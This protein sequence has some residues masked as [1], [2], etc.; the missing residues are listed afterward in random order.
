MSVP[1]RARRP[2]LQRA[3]R[4]QPQGGVQ[5]DALE[6]GTADPCAPAPCRQCTLIR[7]MTRLRLWHPRCLCCCCRGLAQAATGGCAARGG[8][9]RSLCAS[10]PARPRALPQGS[11]QAHAQAWPQVACACSLLPMSGNTSQGWKR[12]LCMRSGVVSRLLKLSR[13][14]PQPLQRC[15]KGSQVRM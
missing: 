6:A 13:R 8:A 5:C 14:G 7:C 4:D 12:H 9:V 11:L 10:G 15:S 2:C 3:A 1:P